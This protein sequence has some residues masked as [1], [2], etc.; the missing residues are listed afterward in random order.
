MSL[1]DTVDI[2]NAKTRKK[3]LLICLEI[4]YAKS[5]LIQKHEKDIMLRT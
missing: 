3:K 1:A 4:E 2:E 5:E